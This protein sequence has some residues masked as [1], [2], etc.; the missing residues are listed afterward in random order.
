[1]PRAV[2]EAGVTLAQ[3]IECL[4]TPATYRTA[5][6]Y[7]PF[8]RPLTGND[9]VESIETHM[10]WV[11]KIG[12]DV[13][14]MLKPVRMPFLDFRPLAR[15]RYF[16]EEALRLNRRLAPD[17]YQGVVALVRAP[18]GQLALGGDG[19]PVEWLLQMRRLPESLMLDRCILDGRV[20]AA[21]VARVTRVLVAFYRQAA[22][23][24]VEPGPH[25]EA[26]HARIE[27]TRA[28][29][30]DPAF[31][32]VTSQVDALCDRAV[33]ALEDLRPEIAARVAGGRIV[34]AHGD[35]RPEHVCLLPKP[36]IID[37]LEFDP[38][39]RCID[40]ADELAYLGLECT[41]LGA[42]DIG[43]QIFA[44]YT[45]ETDDRPSPALVHFYALCRAT[46]R[47]KIAAWHIRDY[48]ATQHGAW[49]NQARRYLALAHAESV[50]LP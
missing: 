17:V 42:A 8:N 40:V 36:V 48:P 28:A 1:M 44:L 7:L 11:F 12:G 22:P 38:A 20:T 47:A 4:Q 18:D 32:F 5:S 49:L 27:E 23:V 14:K 41:A 30:H 35:L 25:I 3:K 13:F 34:D 16:T 19:M 37:C 43:A 10:S 21:D 46:L 39:L 2:D 15:R 29:L 31:G 9:R 6:E 24:Q 26:L 45:I 50:A 33:S